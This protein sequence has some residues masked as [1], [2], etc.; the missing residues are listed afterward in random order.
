M[1]FKLLIKACSPN[2]VIT[3]G[4]K[5]YNNVKKMLSVHSGPR[6]TDSIADI[7]TLKGYNILPL[8]HPGRLGRNNRGKQVGA[9]KGMSGIVGEKQQLKDISIVKDFL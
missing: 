3:F 8:A 2:I 1:C 7:Q 9:A 5:T 6:Y 4:M